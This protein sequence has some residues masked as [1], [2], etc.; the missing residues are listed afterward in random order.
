MV[1]PPA[2]L[3]PVS[4]PPASAPSSTVSSSRD[5]ILVLEDEDHIAGLLSCIL[6][7]GGFNVLRARGAG[8]GLP[9][10]ARYME[11]IALV[12]LDCTLVDADGGAVC[13]RLRERAAG[14]PVLFVSGRD[15]TLARDTLA[16]GGPTGFMPKPFFPAEVMRRARAL[17][18]ATG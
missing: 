4:G 6:E 18:G 1:A 3:L 16:A 7:R 8:D 10:F 12:L 14:L 11:R 5:T 15:L 2:Y 13:L 9:L 17:I